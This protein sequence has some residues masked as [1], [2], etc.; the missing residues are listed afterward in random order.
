LNRR[1][2]RD[3]EKILTEEREGNEDVEKAKS[4]EE[5]VGG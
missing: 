5:A 3:A 1:A 2:Q 4:S